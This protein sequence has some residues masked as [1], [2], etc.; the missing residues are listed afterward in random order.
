MEQ[1]EIH[2][3]DR[4][5]ALLAAFDSMADDAQSTALA[6]MQSIARGSPRRPASGLRLVSSRGQSLNLR[7]SPS[8][9]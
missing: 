9:I 8:G 7:G 2:Q 3:A 6:M 4:R 5:A 1:N